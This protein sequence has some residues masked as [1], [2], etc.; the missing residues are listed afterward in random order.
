MLR[1]LAAGRDYHF[2][3]LDPDLSIRID[4]VDKRHQILVA[5]TNLGQMSKIAQ[6]LHFGGITGHYYLLNNQLKSKHQ[7]KNQAVGTGFVASRHCLYREL[8]RNVDWIFSNNP[9]TIKKYRDAL[10]ADQ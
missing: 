8:N 2:L 5:E 9:V 1:P 3:L 7:R 4:F 10:L 6:Q